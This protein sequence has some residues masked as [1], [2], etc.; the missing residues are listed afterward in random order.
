MTNPNHKA[1]ALQALEQMGLPNSEI[2]TLLKFSH[3]ASPEAFRRQNREV[4]EQHEA[5][6][7]AA[8][9]WVRQQPD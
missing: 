8:M 6:I 5:R 9:D 2:D 1:L 7:Q 3:T 4:R